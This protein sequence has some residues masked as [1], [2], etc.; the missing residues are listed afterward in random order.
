MCTLSL[1][2]RYQEGSKRK[3]R[4]SLTG[5]VVGAGAL[6]D[7]HRLGLVALPYCCICPCFDD[8]YDLVSLP[9]QDR[10]SVG[11]AAW[12]TGSGR[13]RAVWSASGVAGSHWLGAL[14]CKGGGP[15]SS[16]GFSNLV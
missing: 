15:G 8:G 10:G 5:A 6:G 2:G 7:D 4:R 3:S 12:P 13:L 14:H 11:P 9:L 16:R 1:Y